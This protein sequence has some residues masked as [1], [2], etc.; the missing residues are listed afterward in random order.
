M[1][2]H[3]FRL[4]FSHEQINFIL[5]VASSPA[6]LIQSSN[7]SDRKNEDFRDFSIRNFSFQI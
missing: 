3:C 4:E 7:Q 2:L 6:V 5:N 1:S